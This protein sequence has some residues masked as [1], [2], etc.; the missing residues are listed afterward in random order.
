MNYFSFIVTCFG[1]PKDVINAIH[2][3]ATGKLNFHLSLRYAIMCCSLDWGAGYFLPAHVQ[4]IAIRNCSRKNNI[5]FVF[6]VLL[7]IKGTFD[8]GTNH[9]NIMLDSFLLVKGTQD[10]HTATTQFVS[11]VDG[12]QKCSQCRYVLFTPFLCVNEIWDKWWYLKNYSTH[13]CRTLRW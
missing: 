5:T 13:S 7:I 12:I 11:A 4:Y 2:N 3:I 10:N 9:F 8:K 1:S 6:F